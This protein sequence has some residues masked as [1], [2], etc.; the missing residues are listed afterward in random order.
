MY[1]RRWMCQPMVTVSS[2]RLLVETERDASGPSHS[3]KMP[4]AECH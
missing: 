1:G 2:P 4:E 3:P